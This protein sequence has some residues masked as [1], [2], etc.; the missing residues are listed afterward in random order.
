MTLS[1]KPVH[2]V[3]P[4][5]TLRPVSIGRVG[6][7]SGVLGEATQRA[8]VTPFEQALR[9]AIVGLRESLARVE[10]E[11]DPL[12]RHLGFRAL[13]RDV[14]ARHLDEQK[15][16]QPED[17]AYAQQVLQTARGLE[18]QSF[19][20]LDAAARLDLEVLLHFEERLHARHEAAS[21]RTAATRDEAAERAQAERLQRDLERKCAAV[22]RLGSATRPAWLRLLGLVL[23]LLGVMALS[24]ALGRLPW[25]VGAWVQGASGPRWTTVL[26]AVALTALGAWLSVD[27]QRR[28]AW[29]LARAQRLIESRRGA[30]LRVARAEEALSRARK[31]FE[32]IDDEC[33]REEAAA[34]AVLQRRPGAQRYV[35]SAG[36]VVVRPVG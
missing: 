36:G 25:I 17:Q 4:P 34:L 31:L 32:E 14:A 3:A 29:L 6:G 15:L 5:W 21:Q 28:R 9:E 30:S 10:R 12:T 11:G 26:G 16:S 19:A 22:D 20:S 35:N 24:A 27:P 2:G 23:A 13:N 18:A 8:P 1:V 33:R 7:A